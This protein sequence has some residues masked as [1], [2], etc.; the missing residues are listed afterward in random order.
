MRK[1]KSIIPKPHAHLH[2]M[3]KTSAM[4]QNN[5]KKT[6]GVAS[7][8]YALSVHFD[9][10]S[11]QKRTKFT[12]QKK[13]E[14][15]IKG[16]YPNHMHIFIPCWKHRIFQNNLWKTVKGVAPTRY[17]AYF[18]IWKVNW[19]WRFHNKSIENLI[20]PQGH[21]TPKWL[22]RSSRNSNSSEILC[23][24]WLPASLTK[25]R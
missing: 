10:I 13:W 5:W 16:L 3:L 1:N 17:P 2:S 7:T 22:I 24:S 4:F 18:Y 15:I 20:R 9:S 11:Y 25:I 23:L 21:V 8:R 19:T 12:K 14:K 6:V